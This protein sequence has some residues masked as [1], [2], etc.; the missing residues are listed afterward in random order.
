[1]RKNHV[2]STRAE[3]AIELGSRRRVGAVYLALKPETKRSIGPRSRVKISREGRT[4][5][6]TVS[7]KDANALR[8]ALNSYLRWVSGSLDLI[9]VVNHPE[10]LE[11]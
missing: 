4:L 7:A 1:M 9:R 11:E 10:S 5:R 8:A 3:I 2:K 6:L